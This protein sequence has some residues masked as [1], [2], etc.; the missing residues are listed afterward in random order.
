LGVWI[1][2]EKTAADPLLETARTFP[3]TV[4][5]E[6]KGLLLEPKLPGMTI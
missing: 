4:P 2:S 1:V 3:V 5:S 6:V